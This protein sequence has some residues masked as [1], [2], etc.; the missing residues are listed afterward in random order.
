L[1]VKSRAMRTDRVLFDAK[2]DQTTAFDK[3]EEECGTSRRGAKQ[4]AL[5]SRLS[6]GYNPMHRYLM[7]R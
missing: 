3:R 4:A 7:T 2:I 6:H 1:P 5:S